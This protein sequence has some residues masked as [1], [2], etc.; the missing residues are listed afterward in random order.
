MSA[1]TGDELD[2]IGAAEEMQLT[3]TRRDGT[4]R[5]SLPVWAVRV[6]DRLFVRSVKGAEGL[7][8]R[9]ALA[10]KDGRV[11]SG[12]VDKDVGFVKTD[13]HADEIDDAFWAKY[14][15][16]WASIVPSIVRPEARATTLEL[17]PR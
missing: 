9:A 16:R 1:W 12:G 13:D 7:W 5:K 15:Q 8:Y 4:A 10:T 6:G 17:V 3:T 11:S 14:G 2:R